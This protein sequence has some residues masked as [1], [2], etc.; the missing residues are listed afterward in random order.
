MDVRVEIAIF[1]AAQVGM[2]IWLLSGLKEEVKN[3]TGWIRN[4]DARSARTADLAAELKGKV[5]A[6]LSR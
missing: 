3:L 4:I 6:S 1:A 2:L 5:E